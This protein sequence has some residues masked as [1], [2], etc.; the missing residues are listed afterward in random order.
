MTAPLAPS[1]PRAAPRTTGALLVG[2]VAVGAVLRLRKLGER[3]LFGDE[4][5]SLTLARDLGGDWLGSGV[6][7]AS[8]GYEPFARWASFWIA[9]GALDERLFRLPAALAGIALVVAVAALALRSLRP[10]EAVLTTGFVALS[11]YLVYGSREARGYPIAILA[12]TLSVFFVWRWLSR[13]SSAAHDVVAAVVAAAIASALDV[14]VAPSLLLVALVA[15]A[16]VQLRGAWA[17]QRRA[18]AAGA[19]TAIACALTLLPTLRGMLSEA[20]RASAESTPDLHT[21]SKGLELAVGLPPLAIIPLLLLGL[22]RLQRRFPT[23]VRLGLAAWIAQCVVLFLI[24]PRTVDVPWVALRYVVHLLPL[25]LV[26]AAAALAPPQ[27]W[28]ARNPVAAL[29]L[30]TALLASFGGLQQVLGRYDALTEAC[31]V[32][33]P[34][35][36]DRWDGRGDAAVREAMPAFY[37]EELPRLPP[38]NVI[39]APLLVSQPLYEWYRRQHQRGCRVAGAGNGLFQATVTPAPGLAL[40]RTLHAS[41]LGTNDDARDD[42]R[43]LILHKRPWIEMARISAALRRAGLLRH[44]V[45]AS[46][47]AAIFVGDVALPAKHPLDQ[48]RLIHEDA[49]VRVYQLPPR[50]TP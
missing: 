19:L 30:A 44:A 39:E 38:G 2:L 24:G 43:F 22:W 50:R 28:S 16:V 8:G 33:H 48:G 20:G 41:T 45:D 14:A 18:L 36:W 26:V 42:G 7:I 32:S 40:E 5:H 4:I 29:A 6:L 31:V 49:E 1:A 46:T 25:G 35:A 34:L 47:A 10:N 3:A 9:H 27:A 23:R 12:F 37:R 11:P 17:A 21:L 15:L 13:R